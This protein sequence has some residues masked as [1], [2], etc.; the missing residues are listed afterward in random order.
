VRK[1]L[2]LFTALTLILGSAGIV[3]AETL[4]VGLQNFRFSPS[5][6]H[7]RAGETVT[8]HLV[9]LARGGHSFTAPAFFSS[10]SIIPQSRP[11]VRN[12]TVE[13]LGGQSV[14]LTLVPKAGRYPVKCDHSF[15]KMMGMSGTIL[16]D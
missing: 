8:L 9:N 13:V 2:Q 1:A 16:V 6:L 11:I 7:L 12:G 10:S 5:A 14:D 4:T 15:H 3:R